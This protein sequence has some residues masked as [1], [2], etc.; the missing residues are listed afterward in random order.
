MPGETAFAEQKPFAAEPVAAAI[1]QAEHGRSPAVKSLQQDRIAETLF[2]KTSGPCPALE[3]RAVRSCFERAPIFAQGSPVG[4]P[5]QRDLGHPPAGMSA[6]NN[7]A[8]VAIIASWS[9]SVFALTWFAAPTRA[10]SAGS[11]A[12]AVI[13]SARSPGSSGV[14]NA[15]FSSATIVATS[16]TSVEAMGRPDA[17]ASSTDKGI[18]SVS[19]ERAK[20]SNE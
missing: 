4:Y 19:D 13:A 11:R 14:T 17:I 10:R 8:Y 1:E 5:A 9:K 18:C 2:G 7:A 6:S 3:E 12:R 16:P 15:R 20:M